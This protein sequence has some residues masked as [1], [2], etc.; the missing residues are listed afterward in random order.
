MQFE[1]KTTIGAPPQKVWEFLTN[2]D[3]VSQCAPGLESMEII[4]PDEKFRAVASV[5]LG[6]MKV[7]FTTDV[8]WLELDAPKHARMRAHGKAPGSTV[9]ATAEMDL[10]AV[11][12][13][14]TELNWTANV[15]IQGTIA[16]LASR[17]M[18]SVTERLT[19]EFF[20]CVKDK[21]E[22]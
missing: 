20:N 2:P 15:T 14:T 12:D 21:V 3:Q 11:D 17:L 16:S 9:D 8:E 6:S 22:S 13:Q 5:G 7:R 10:E 1:G 18:G 4:S 19:G